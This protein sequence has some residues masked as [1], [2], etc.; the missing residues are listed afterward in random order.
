MSWKEKEMCRNRKANDLKG[1]GWKRKLME[2][3][4]VG[5]GS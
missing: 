4:L 3:V 1:N 2:K 5:E